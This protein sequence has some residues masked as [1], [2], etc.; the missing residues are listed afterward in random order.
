MQSN[1]LTLFA[2]MLIASTYIF[3]QRDLSNY[4]NIEGVYII[5]HWG[6]I[7]VEGTESNDS[8]EFNVE[9]IFTDTSKKSKN[10]DDFFNYMTFEVKKN[11]LYI[12]TRKPTGF[13][14]IE[15]NIKIPAH[16]LLEIMLKKGGNI[17]VNNFTNGV[18]INSLNGSV[19]LNGICEYALV[20]ATNGEI[21]AEFDKINRNKP[22]SLITLNGGVTV[23]L[24]GNS[25]RDLRLISRKNGYIESDFDIDTEE[26]ILNLNQKRYAKQAIINKGKIN[27]GGSLLFLSTENGPIA[28]KKSKS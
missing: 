11:K 28:I 7:N 24:P 14:S 25:S 10:I 15:L 3:G 6:N 13:E 26:R 18:E 12:E 20:N 17:F 9:A 1:K 8:P 2:L 4:K 23:V 19:K 5:S 27:G 21:K 22:I 16:L